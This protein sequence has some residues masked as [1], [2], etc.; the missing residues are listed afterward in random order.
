M[1]R[2]F[3]RSFFLGRFFVLSACGI[4][5]LCALG[6]VYPILFAASGVVFFLWLALVAADALLLFS[7]DVHLSATRILPDTI[8][9]G[10][11]VLVNLQVNLKATRS[12]ESRVIDELPAQFQDRN[13]GFQLD[14]Q[15]G[16][17]TLSYP[18]KALS[19]GIYQFG[20]VRV[21]LES[22]LHLLRRGVA[23]ALDRTVAAYPSVNQMRELELRAFSRLA[24]QQGAK[25]YTRIGQSYEFEQISN[26]VEGDDY[27][28]I[29]WKATGKRSEL[30][31]NQFRDERNQNLYC[32]ISKGRAMRDSF[33]GMSLLDYAINSALAISNVALKKYDHVG[34]ITYSDKIGTALRAERRNG[35]IQR[36]LEILYKERSRDLEPS[37]ELLYQS[38]ER[39]IKTRSLLLLYANFEQPE[40]LYRVLPILKKINQKHM[41]MMILFR[42]VELAERA[43]TA[44][45]DLDSLYTTT[46]AQQAMAQREEIAAILRNQGIRT[47]VSKPHELSIDVINSYLEIK[48][49]GII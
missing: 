39:I 24:S 32:I 21:Y 12:F 4:I 11:E 8:G 49:K 9:L 3:W 22:P 27:R 38:I 7:K 18:I 30:M 13:F 5:V 20:N 15:P 10:D 44:H 28:N 14:L 45:T 42:D 29:N 23:L 19:R 37:Y 26:Y 17:N 33:A 40:M 25:R 41:L 47:I 36:I 35:Q 16:T 43:E 46:L 31:I 34:L 6:F 2:T 48:S 1:I